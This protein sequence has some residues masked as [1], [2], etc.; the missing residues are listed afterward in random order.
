MQD[1]WQMEANQELWQLWLKA[2]AAKMY[3]SKRTWKRKHL[4]AEEIERYIKVKRKVRPMMKE[5]KENC[6]S[7]IKKKNNNGNIPVQSFLLLL[8]LLLLQL[9]CD[10]LWQQNTTNS[11]EHKTK[12]KKTD[13]ESFEINKDFIYFDIKTNC[14][15][16]L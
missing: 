13:T 8:L 4:E 9:F 16:L 14:Q 1:Y 3:T 5:E 7:N 10:I 2:E 12:N 6:Y 15:A 11:K